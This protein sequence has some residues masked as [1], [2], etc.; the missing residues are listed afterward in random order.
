[1]IKRILT[2]FLFCWI[3][4]LSAQELSLVNG[5]R[6]THSVKVKKGNYQ[7]VAPADTGTFCDPGGGE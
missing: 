3:S 5:M 6:I 4:G 7:L 1:M 2:I